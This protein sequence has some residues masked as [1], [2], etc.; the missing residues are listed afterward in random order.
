MERKFERQFSFSFEKMVSFYFFVYFSNVR[1]LYFLVFA[2]PLF[3]IVESSK[4]MWFGDTLPESLERYNFII[5]V[6]NNWLSFTENLR[7][8]IS[9]LERQERLQPRRRE[10]WLWQTR[11]QIALL[12]GDTL[13]KDL[14]WNEERQNNKIRGHWS[15]CQLIVRTYRWRKIPSFVIGPQQVEVS[16]W[17]TSLTTEELQ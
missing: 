14:S 12:L 4:V 11:N 1:Q 3:R 8:Y 7:L 6:F 15:K 10:D 16:Y 13:L 5:K 9:F 2:F 17:S